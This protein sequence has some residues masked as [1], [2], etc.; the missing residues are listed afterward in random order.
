MQGE[1]VILG[2]DHGMRYGFTIPPLP[3]ERYEFL[4]RVAKA[5]GITQR[6]VVITALDALL[7]L[8]V[9]NR[10]KVDVLVEEVKGES[11]PGRKP[12]RVEEEG[13]L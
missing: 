3:K 12:K 13:S 6:Q 1:F 2:K 10:T 11:V 8:G 4:Q 9:E 7:A 5:Y